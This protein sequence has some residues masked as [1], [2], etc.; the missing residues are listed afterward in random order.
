MTE[1]DISVQRARTFFA[2]AFPPV[3]LL[4]RYILKTMT[5]AAKKGEFKNTKKYVFS[6]YQG[7]RSYN[8]ITNDSLLAKNEIN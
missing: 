3:K 5:R 1:V 2:T 4:R 8:F 6:M 7:V